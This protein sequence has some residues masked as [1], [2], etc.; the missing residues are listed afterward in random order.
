MVTPSLSDRDRFLNGVSQVLLINYRPQFLDEGVTEQDHIL[1]YYISFVS[2]AH[3]QYH[4]SI[5]KKRYSN[6]IV[7]D[8]SLHSHILCYQLHLSKYFATNHYQVLYCLWECRTSIWLSGLS[9]LYQMSSYIAFYYLINWLSLKRSRNNG[10][11]FTANYHTM[12]R[13]SEREGEK[14]SWVPAGWSVY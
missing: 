7:L 11:S 13:P 12:V 6:T 8:L 3:R 1:I 9:Y 5:H 10:G 14:G 2:L 4:Y